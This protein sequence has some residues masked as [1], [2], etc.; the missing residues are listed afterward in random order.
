MIS[1]PII[2]KNQFVKQFFDF[3]ELVNQTVKQS[4]TSHRYIL[5]AAFLSVIDSCRRDP[6]KFNILYHNLP[7]SATTTSTPL[8][9]FNMTLPYDSS[10]LSPDEQHP[11]Y[12]HKNA[13]DVA[14][15]KFLVDEAEQFFSRKIK[16]LEQVCINQL[17]ETLISASLS[18][19][20]TKKSNKDPEA[21][22]YMQNIWERKEDPLL[23]VDSNTWENEVWI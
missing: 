2:T 15:W 14:Y 23:W 7:S 22:R 6:T 12:Q 5:K 1:I 20:L 8:A 11:Y 17:I 18:S 4:L 10:G 21:L 16:E 13:N 19:Q 9:E 3:A